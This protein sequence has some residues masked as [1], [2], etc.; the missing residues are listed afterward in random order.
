MRAIH[1]AQAI[2]SL[3]DSANTEADRERV[4]RN[5]AETIIRNGHRALAP[6]ILRQLEKLLE[7]A[8]KERTIVVSS[9]NPIEESAV[10]K[11]LKTDPLP[12][13]LSRAHKFVERVVDPTLI[14]GYVVRTKGMRVDMSRKRLLLNLYHHLTQ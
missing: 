6:K 14:G 12:A 3:L 2:K 5:A 10:S 9:A 8:K 1:Y 7:A 4:I 13:L 11:I